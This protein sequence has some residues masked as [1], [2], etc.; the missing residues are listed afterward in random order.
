MKSL[1]FLIAL[2][3]SV[4]F[5]LASVSGAETDEQTR[6]RKAATD[7]AGAFANDGFKT[8]DGFWVGTIKRGER[9]LVAVN[10]YAGNQYWF[11]AGASDQAKRIAVNVFDETGR[12]VTTEPY[13]AE[14][15]AAAGFSPGSSGQY[16]VS[17]EISEGDDAVCCLI[18]S[19]K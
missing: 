11:S 14:G 6:A 12:Q 19:Y 5:A 9:T 2:L 18:Y 1:R 17:L 7:V 16:Y 15:K 3:C 13:N 10:L 8:R 4:A